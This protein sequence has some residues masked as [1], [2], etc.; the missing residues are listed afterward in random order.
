VEGTLVMIVFFSL[1]MAVVDCGQILF[2]HEALV[3]RTRSAVR[4]GVLHAWQGPDPI[5]NLVLYGQPEE[6]NPS[7][8]GY[9]GMAATNVQVT[10]QPPQAG[11]ADDEILTV[12][13]VNYQPH[14]FSPWV[15]TRFVS[16]RPVLISAPM[17]I[18]GAVAQTVP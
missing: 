15:G 10:Y 16:N 7:Q 4:W 6:P 11:N 3:E 14:L 8:P 5:V 2:A 9:L 13:I 1:L 17:A 18:R 12:R